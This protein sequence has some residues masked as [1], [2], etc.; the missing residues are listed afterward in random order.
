LLGARG[1][2]LNQALSYSNIVFG[3]S[4]CLWLL[5]GLT[6]I[7]RGTGDMKTPARIAIFRA[8]AALPLF[9][10]LIFGWGPVAGFGIA[11]AATAMLIYYTMGVIGLVVH[12]Q[13]AKSPIYLAFGLPAAVATLFAHFESRVALVAADTGFQRRADRNNGLCC[14]LRY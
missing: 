5:G 13:S 6:A 3:G 8:A 4:I 14:S 2:S 9:G 10:M 12:L 11:G 7:V 1:D